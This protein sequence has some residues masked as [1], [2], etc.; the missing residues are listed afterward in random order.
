M[1]ISLV[2]ANPDGTM[3]V[4]VSGLVDDV[5]NAIV[6]YATLSREQLDGAAD[7][8]DDL[9]LMADFESRRYQLAAQKP[10]VPTICIAR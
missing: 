10:D 1:Q 6:S 4:E 9:S 8:L 5:G 3:V 7:Q 2:R